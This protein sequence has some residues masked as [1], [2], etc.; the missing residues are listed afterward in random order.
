MVKILIVKPH[1]VVPDV[2]PVED[3]FGYIT[4]AL[5]D[6]YSISES[7]IKLGP[8]RENYTFWQR[9][10]SDVVMQEMVERITDNLLSA[11]DL[12]NLLYSAGRFV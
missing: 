4:N 1:T 12:S 2:G 10:S 3:G 6:K 8:A 5:L 7:T 9:I 11:A